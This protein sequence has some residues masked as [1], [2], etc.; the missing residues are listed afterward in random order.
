MPGHCVLCRLATSRTMDLCTYCETDLPWL[1]QQ[2]TRCGLPNISSANKLD[3]NFSV[4]DTKLFSGISNKNPIEIQNSALCALCTTREDK[5]RTHFKFIDRTFSPL[6]YSGCARW[7]VQQQKGSKGGVYGRVL[8]ELLSNAL[9]KDT[10]P[11]SYT[12]LTLPTKA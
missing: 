11:V 2:C 12:H 4:T 5:P 1:F 3:D 7:M 10:H 6:S 8:A 9:T